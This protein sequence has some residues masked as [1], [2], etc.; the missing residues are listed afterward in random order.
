MYS[1]VGLPEGS[2]WEQIQCL[3]YDLTAERPRD[4]RDRAMIQL[5][6]VYGMRIG[7]VCGLLPDDA[8]QFAAGALRGLDLY[9][10][11]ESRT[12]RTNEVAVL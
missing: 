8:K 5:R 6:S 4:I 2:T 12:T 9:E 11:F 7:E 1:M 10:I 3:L